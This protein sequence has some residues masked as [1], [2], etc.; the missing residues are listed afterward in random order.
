[1]EWPSPFG[2][3]GSQKATEINQ[4]LFEIDFG[5]NHAPPIFL[6][7][8]NFPKSRKNKVIARNIQLKEEK[9]LNKATGALTAISCFFQ[10]ILPA[11][12]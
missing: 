8:F 12:E 1:M 6:K 3:L 9:C 7:N 5:W 2:R 10:N 4:N 11:K